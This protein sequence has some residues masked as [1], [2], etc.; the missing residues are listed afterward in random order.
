[1]SLFGDKPLVVYKGG[2]SRENGQ[3]EAADTRLFQIRANPAGNTRTVEVRR[4]L[5]PSED[6]FFPFRVLVQK[7]KVPLVQRT[8]QTSG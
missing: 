4:E 8:S 2:T 1:M 6:R 3:S 7:I 5:E